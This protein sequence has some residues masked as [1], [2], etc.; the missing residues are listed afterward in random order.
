MYRILIVDD[1]PLFAGGLKKLFSEKELCSHADFEPAGGD[2]TNVLSGLAYDL[3]LINVSFCEKELLQL[4]TNNNPEI[5]ILA[6]SS[7]PCLR[8]VGRRVSTDLH[9]RRRICRVGCVWPATAAP[10]IHIARDRA[11]YRATPVEHSASS[12]GH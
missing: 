7:Q 5:S 4:L 1:Q 6:I 12:C 9:R 2:F 8:C 3:A 10:G 11:H